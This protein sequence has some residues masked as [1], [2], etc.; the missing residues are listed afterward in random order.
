MDLFSTDSELAHDGRLPADGAAQPPLSV[1]ALVNGLKALVEDGYSDVVVEGELSNF[2][3]A[4]SGHCYFTLKDAE[5][6]IDGV[7]WRYRAQQLFFE[8]EDGL[9]VQLTGDATIYE[10]RGR[11]QVAARAMTLAGEGALQ[12]AF[13][14]LKTRLRAEGLFDAAC[15]RELPLYPERIGLVTSGQSAALQD[16]LSVLE[17][18]FPQV[19]VTLAPVPVQGLGAAPAIARAIGAFNALSPAE[20]RPDL[21]IVGRGGGSAEDLWAFNEE[22][23]ARAIFASNIPTISGVGHET[24]V[25]IADFTADVRAATPSMAAELAVPDRRETAALVRSLCDRLH[26]RTTGRL[27]ESRRRVEHLTATRTFLRPVD[28]LHAT[29]QRLDDLTGRLQRAGTH[30]VAQHHRD[31]DRLHLR[32]EAAHPEAPLRRGYACIERDSHPV[33]A[34]AELG[35]GDAVTLRFLDGRRAARVEDA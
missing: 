24:D 19:Q 23:V 1:S 11:L 26:E 14:E 16:L 32:L 31:L 13:E 30:V 8:P 9:R 28:R 29:A 17:R 35:A 33:R 6:Q 15:K 10:R 3:R 22:E 20:G 2:H 12:K 4:R 27:R 7:M 25:S 5:A 21:L 34:A 18:R